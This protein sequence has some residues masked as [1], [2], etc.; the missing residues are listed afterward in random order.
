M[1]AVGIQTHDTI[2][3]KHNVS[4]M[5]LQSLGEQAFSK[6]LKEVARA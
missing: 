5:D 2:W 6:L 4:V 3:F 1:I